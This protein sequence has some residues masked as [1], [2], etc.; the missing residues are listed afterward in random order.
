M[1][2]VV[3]PRPPEV[4]VAIHSRNRWAIAAAVRLAMRRA[5]KDRAEI[6]RFLR[7]ALSDPDP[8]SFDAAC[9]PW[10]RLEE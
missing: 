6:D 1:A 2:N 10:V 9:R 5:G 7:E 3:P 8:A 4:R